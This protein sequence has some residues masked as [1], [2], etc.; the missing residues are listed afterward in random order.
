D[1]MHLESINIEKA[2][3]GF[4]VSCCYRE[5]PKNRKKGEET[6]PSG[7]IEPKKHIFRTADEVS[8]FVNEELGGSTPLDKTDPA[9]YRKRRE[10]GEGD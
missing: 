6:G 8:K 5:E 1:S 7:Y 10:Q 4:T 2:E 9:E 3:N